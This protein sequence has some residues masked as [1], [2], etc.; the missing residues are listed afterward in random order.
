MTE[1]VAGDVPGTDVLAE[2]A[3]LIAAL[4]SHPN[5]GVR[6]Q[7]A[8]LLEGIDTVHRTALTHLFNAV[9][10]IG[11]DAF[12]NKLIA[13]PAVRMLLMSYELLAVDRR[14]LAE[15]ALDAV[16]GHLHAHGVD[17]ELLDVAGSEVFVRLHGI[18][19]TDLPADAVQRDVEAALRAGLVGFHALVVG[20]RPVMRAAELIQLGVGSA[21][22]PR[23]QMVLRE[24][25]LVEGAMLAT[26][27]GDV[28]VLLARV[29]GA[30]Y[31]VAN[32]CGDSP[33][34][35]GYSELEGATIVCSWHGCRYDIR[36]GNRLDRPGEDRLRVFPVRVENGEIQIAVGVDT[37][38]LVANARG[39]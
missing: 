24:D 7:V 18:E 3:R 32:S 2:T 19:S 15:E 38:R 31:A 6:E 22:R 30:P 33:L 1:P 9:Q 20:D 29:D 21:A 28:D 5:A 13:D 36:T 26:Q 16:R 35:L 37:T 10:G 8:A 12:V 25:E 27:V 4:E 39:E 14:L 17:V 11:G 34:P 23:Y